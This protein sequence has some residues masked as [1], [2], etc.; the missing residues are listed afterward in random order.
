MEILTALKDGLACKQIADGLFISE[1]TV[2]KHIEH[3]YRK[4]QVNNKVSAVNITR[5]NKWL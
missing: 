2:R 4:L 5:A 1:G 3:I